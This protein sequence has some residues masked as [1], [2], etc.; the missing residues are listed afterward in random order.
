MRGTFTARRGPDNQFIGSFE[1]TAPNEDKLPAMLA[2]AIV[3]L[4]GLYAGALASGQLAPDASLNMQPQLDQA[5]IDSIVAKA[6]PAPAATRA[7]ADTADTEVTASAPVV[8]D[9]TVTVQIATPDSAAF[10]AGMGAVRRIAGVKDRREHQPGHWRH[11]GAARDLR[12][13]Y[14]HAG[15]SAAGAGLEGHARGRRAQHPQ[16]GCWFD[17]PDSPA[18]RDGG[19]ARRRS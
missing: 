1:L 18:P 10:D 9:V 16:V 12:G 14:R 6:A 15:G 4:D 11:V 7:S 5:L 3:R 13:R 19:P 17:E 8:P 2:E